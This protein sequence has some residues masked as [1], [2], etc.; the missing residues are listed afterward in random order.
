MYLTF[1]WFFFFFFEKKK[2]KKKKKK[3]EKRGLPCM[4]AKC[5]RETLDKCLNF[6]HNTCKGVGGK[7]S[8]E[9]RKIGRKKNKRK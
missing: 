1:F 5:V 7:T 3:K 2:I 4:V 6:Q 9:S 8:V